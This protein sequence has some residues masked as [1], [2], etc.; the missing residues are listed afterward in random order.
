MLEVFGLFFNA[1]S[2]AVLSFGFILGLK[3]ATDSDHIAAV[4]TIISERKSVWSSAIVGGLWGVGHTASLLI[5]GIFVLLL[6]FEITPRGERV[7][8]FLAGTM[9]VILGLNVFRKLLGGGKLHFHA[10]THNGTTHVHPHIH[11]A[12]TQDAPE[13]HHGIGKFSPRAVLIGMVHGLAGSAAVMLIVLPT[14]DSKLVGLLYIVIF[15]IGSIGGMMI[16]SFFIGVPF[17]L[18][19][20]GRFLRFNLALQTIAAVASVG[21]GLFVIYEKGFVEGLLG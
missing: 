11:E 19:A 21:L 14:I 20:A 17:R 4:S 10:H 9:L 3:H 15:G 6:G 2:F 16:M 13:A 7:F 8:E 18:T 1:S 5:A 12:G